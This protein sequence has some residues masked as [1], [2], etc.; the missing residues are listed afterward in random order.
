[1]ELN[2]YQIKA[3]ETSI[4]GQKIASLLQPIKDLQDRSQT[5]LDVSENHHLTATIA[6]IEQLL[7]LAYASLG[8]ASEAGEVAGLIK[9]MI[10]DGVPTDFDTKINKEVGDCLWYVAELATETK[11]NI[12]DIAQQNNDKLSDRA[13]RGQIQG[14]GDNR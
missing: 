4:Y 5:L 10:R 12:S 9:K 1:M 14:S 7:N 2:T 11:T 8:L 6:Q 3:R 13:A